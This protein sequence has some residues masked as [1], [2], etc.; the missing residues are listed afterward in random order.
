MNTLVLKRTPWERFKKGL[1]KYWEYYLMLIPGFAL[2]ITFHMRL[3]TASCWPL[4]ISA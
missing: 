4:K 3:C 2:L 1:F